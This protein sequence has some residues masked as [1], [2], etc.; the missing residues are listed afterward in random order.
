MIS[1]NFNNTAIITVKSVDYR[2]NIYDVSKSDVMDL[3]ENY[4]LDDRG[5]I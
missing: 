5:F 1:P 4:G 3:L 2:C